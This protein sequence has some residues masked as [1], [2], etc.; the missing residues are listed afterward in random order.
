MPTRRANSTLVIRP[1][2]CRFCRMRRSIRSS[3]SRR[4]ATPLFPYNHT[5]CRFR[6]QFYCARAAAC[7]PRAGGLRKPGRM[8]ALPASFEP[9]APLAADDAPLVWVLH[10]GKAGMASQS[11]G[12]AEATGFPFVEK[13]LSVRLPWSYLPPQL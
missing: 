13:P 3:L 8:V 9:V 7:L 11:L 10:D 6:T 4:I 2:A 5:N 12:L 1:S